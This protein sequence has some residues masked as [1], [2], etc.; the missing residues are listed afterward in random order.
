MNCLWDLQP[1][2]RGYNSIYYLVTKYQQDIPVGIPSMNKQYFMVMG[3]RLF[4]ALL[5]PWLG[6]FSRGSWRF[7]AP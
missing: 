2:Y 3:I 1:T 7:M 4:L 5:L 6:V